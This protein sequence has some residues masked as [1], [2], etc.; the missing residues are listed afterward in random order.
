MKFIVEKGSISINGVSLTVS[1]VTKIV[2]KSL[3]S[4]TL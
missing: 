1:K 2:F 4:H 3:L